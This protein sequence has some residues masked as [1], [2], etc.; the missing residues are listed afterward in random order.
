VSKVSYDDPTLYAK[1]TKDPLWGKFK[2]LITY[3]GFKKPTEKP[4]KGKMNRN[5]RKS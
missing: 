4:S 2:T 1:A 3:K 5:E